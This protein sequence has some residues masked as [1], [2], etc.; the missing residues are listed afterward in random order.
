M[1]PKTGRP[2]PSDGSWRTQEPRPTPVPRDATNALSVPGSR[3][4]LWRFARLAVVVSAIALGLFIAAVVLAIAHGPSMAVAFSVSFGAVF[5]LIATPLA[6]AAIRSATVMRDYPWQPYHASVIVPVS[7]KVRP[8]MELWSDDDRQPI[9]WHL[10]VSVSTVTGRALGSGMYRHVWMAGD[11]GHGCVV[12]PAGGGPLIWATRDWLRL[13]HET[14]SLTQV[15]QSSAADRKRIPDEF[16]VP[17]PQGRGHALSVPGSSP[18]LR[19]FARR[20]VM[21]WAVMVVLIAVFVVLVATNA[22]PV[23]NIIWAYLA[24]GTAVPLVRR[25]AA[26]TGAARRMAGRPWVLY[27]AKVT[28]PV[29]GKVL[30]EVWPDGDEQSEHR[31]L[32]VKSTR[33]TRVELGSGTYRYV[34]IT[35]GP[36][37]RT[38]LMPAGGGPLV[39]AARHEPATRDVSH[40]P[41]KRRAGKTSSKTPPVLLAQEARRNARALEREKAAEGTTTGEPS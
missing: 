22:P 8:R 32:K 24:I 40:E 31:H 39:W 27:H 36:T 19:L 1:S 34:W 3:N 13:H 29:S 30:M 6:I 12:V 26:V 11:P 23:A 5:A 16:R 41:S 2:D 10:K 28:V 37:R 4:A 35:G 25:T 18:A 20:A 33:A 21:W 17:A 15:S 38:V 7:Q 14:G 9:R